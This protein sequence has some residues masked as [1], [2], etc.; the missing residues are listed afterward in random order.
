M[1]THVYLLLP[2]EGPTMPD[3]ILETF[4]YLTRPF[5]SFLAVLNIQV[6]LSKPRLVGLMVSSAHGSG[7]YIKQIQCSLFLASKCF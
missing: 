4:L 2:I 6:S 7:S 1:F 5:E 3:L